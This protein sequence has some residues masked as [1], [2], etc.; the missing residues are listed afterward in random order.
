ML[1][2]LTGGFFDRTDFPSRVHRCAGKGLPKTPCCCIFFR[3]T[4]ELT[5]PV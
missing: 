4:D 3:H 2:H 5:M 1:A